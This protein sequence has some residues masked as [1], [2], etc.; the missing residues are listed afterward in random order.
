MKE[1]I[2]EKVKESI[3]E[4]CGIEVGLIKP[5]ATL[6]GKLYIDSI[7]MVDIMYSLEMEYDIE[8]KVADINKEAMD[9]L[10]NKPFEINNVITKEGI[11][12]LK[13]RIPGIPNDQLVEGVTVHELT[14][15]ITVEMLCNMVELKINAKT[16]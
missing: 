12:A 13:K 16:E 4:S 8:L 6:F 11:A 2:F 3:I 5:D 9:E 1:E 14:K 7:D 10:G 15:M